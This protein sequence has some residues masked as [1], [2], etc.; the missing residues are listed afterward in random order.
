VEEFKEVIER[1]ERDLPGLA[2][3][4]MPLLDDSGK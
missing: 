3:K 1:L 2:A 4:Q